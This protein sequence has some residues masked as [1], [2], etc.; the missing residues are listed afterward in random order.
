[1][2]NNSLLIALLFVLISV[3][4]CLAQEWD[5][6]MDSYT[7]NQIEKPVTPQEFNKAMETIQSYQ[8]KPKVKKEKKK[9]KNKKE[10]D[11]PV[12]QPPVQKEPTILPSSG[13]LLRLPVSVHRYNIV[14]PNGFYLVEKMIK[15]E[16]YFLRIKQSGKNI[17]DLPAVTTTGKYTGFPELFVRNTG[18]NFIEIIYIDRES[19]IKAELPIYVPGPNDND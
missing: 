5:S 6:I 8:K 3:N 9:K 12:P 13:L 1:M 2:K 18:K 19:C 7:K 15:D 4:C 17:I 14:L 16:G 11:M 10:Q